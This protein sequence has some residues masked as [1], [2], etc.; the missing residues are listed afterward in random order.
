MTEGKTEIEWPHC[1]AGKLTSNNLTCHQ[2]GVIFL[3]VGEAVYVREGA[4]EK[5]RTIVKETDERMMQ[6]AKEKNPED[7]QGFEGEV[8][9]VISGVKMGSMILIDDFIVT[10]TLGP[11]GNFSMEPVLAIDKRQDESKLLETIR[12]LYAEKRLELLL[13]WLDPLELE[14]IRTEVGISKEQFD[15]ELSQL[16]NAGQKRKVGTFHSHESSGSAPS[17][18]DIGSMKIKDDK[19]FDGNH[20]E[21]TTLFPLFCQNS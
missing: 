3:N 20:L 19:L 13:L 14:I 9:G 15:K 1:Q 21:K 10:G 11:A 7:I 16:I 8:A 6:I 12:R 2:C 4:L 17:E 5:V 18:K